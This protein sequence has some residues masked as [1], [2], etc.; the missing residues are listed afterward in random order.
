M[1]DGQRVVVLS[2]AT[3]LAARDG[4]ATVMRLH[5]EG[6]MVVRDG[7]FVSL[8]GGWR[9]HTEDATEAVQ[10]PA[11]LGRPVWRL[12]F[13]T[14]LLVPSVN[15]S[16]SALMARLVA[17]GLSY[18]FV[19]ELRESIMLGRTSLALLVSRG[20][21][22]TILADFRSFHGIAELVD[23]SMPTEAVALLKQALA[24]ARRPRPGKPECR[25]LTARWQANY[26]GDVH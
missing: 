24:Y 23:S 7:A 16:A 1:A 3:R 11:P 6:K 17:V 4:L 15:A 2:F 14:I 26:P 25:L 21:R 12:L 18:R 5:R 10:D 9:A 8:D 13:D 22:D 20:N 19:K